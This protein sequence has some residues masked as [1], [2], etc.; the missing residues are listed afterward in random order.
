M[1]SARSCHEGVRIQLNYEQDQQ[2]ASITFNVVVGGLPTIDDCREMASQAARWDQD[3]AHAGTAYRLF[4]S[5]RSRLVSVEARSMD[6]LS[7]AAWVQAGFDASAY[8]AEVV[9]D[10]LTAN[11]AP[12]MHWEALPGQL[13]MLGRTYMPCLCHNVLDTNHPERMNDSAIPALVECFEGV[14]SLLAIE[15][16]AILVLL[17]TQVGGID[18]RPCPVSQIGRAMVMMPHV[19]TQRRRVEF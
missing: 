17:T 1:S 15:T 19:G 10:P 11:V 5:R 18:I 8:G 16:G 12:I 14:I 9:S 7:K 2:A 13:R 3:G 4:R 6:P